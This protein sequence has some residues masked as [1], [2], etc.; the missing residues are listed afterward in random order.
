M[1][2]WVLERG[3]FWRVQSVSCAWLLTQAS[4]L[5]P[6]RSLSAVA[7]HSFNASTLALKLARTGLLFL[8]PG[9]LIAAHFC[10]STLCDCPL[11]CTVDM[12]LSVKSWKNYGTDGRKFAAATL[13]SKV[14]LCNTVRLMKTLVAWCVISESLNPLGFEE[15]CGQS[16]DEGCSGKCW[17]HKRSSWRQMVT[18]LFS[19][20]L[21]TK[22]LYRLSYTSRGVSILDVLC[23]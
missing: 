13:S 11:E 19:S 6:V 4:A 9:L 2:T 23:S 12:D 3:I 18:D 16:S 8:W 1:S 17:A 10:L 14:G 7:Q 21:L 22:W 20:S 5:I 15:Q